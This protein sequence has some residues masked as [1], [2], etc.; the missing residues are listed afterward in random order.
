[1]KK[2]LLI[3]VLIGCFMV[4]LL[5]SCDSDRFTLET[6][7]KPELTRIGTKIAVQFQLGDL[8]IL[9]EWED[10]NAAQIIYVTSNKDISVPLRIKF[11]N[12]SNNS[13]G[14][15][16]TIGNVE[17]FTSPVDWKILARNVDS[18]PN[19]VW[20]VKDGKTIS[21]KEKSSEKDDL[22]S[23][24]KTSDEDGLEELK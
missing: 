1:M 16:Y 2:S 14:F 23:V 9:D 24:N 10:L 20:S 6:V 21:E 8:L 7:I 3:G 22:Q 13:D 11:G 18:F 19:V 17:I 5:A 12:F 15:Y 4:F